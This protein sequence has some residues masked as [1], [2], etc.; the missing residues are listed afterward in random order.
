MLALFV[1]FKYLEMVWRPLSVLLPRPCPWWSSLNLSSLLEAQSPPK[2][3]WLAVI[4]FVD[5]SVFTVSTKGKRLLAHSN[6]GS[7][8][9]N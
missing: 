8:F 3:D 6:L 1:P 5:K 9:S 2:P 7:S 4:V